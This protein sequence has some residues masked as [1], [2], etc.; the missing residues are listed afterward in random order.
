MLISGHYAKTVNRIGLHDVLI[1]LAARATGAILATGDWGQ[2]KILHKHSREDAATRNLYP[3]Q[4]P[5]VTRGPPHVQ[6]NQE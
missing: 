1:A 5:R 6:E 3:A 4:S 2:G